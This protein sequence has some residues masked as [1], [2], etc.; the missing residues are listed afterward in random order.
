MESWQTDSKPGHIPHYTGC[1]LFFVSCLHI[2]SV[3][4]TFIQNVCKTCSLTL[5]TSQSH[6]KDLPN[7]KPPN[8]EKLSPPCYTVFFSLEHLLVSLNSLNYTVYSFSYY[9]SHIISPLLKY[10]CPQDTGFSA[11]CCR[12]RAQ[13]SV[14]GTSRIMT[15]KANLSFMFQ[16]IFGERCVVLGGPW[17]R[18]LQCIVYSQS[19]STLFCAQLLESF[20]YICEVKKFIRHQLRKSPQ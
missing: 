9:L 5:F 13:N 17:G 19:L 20:K 3:Q 4:N 7:V 2:S 11:Y 1:T 10:K 16:Q 14:P 6:L 12:C 15:L 8:L 18:L